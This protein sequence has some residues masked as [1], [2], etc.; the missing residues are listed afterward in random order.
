MITER[1]AIEAQQLLDNETLK[2]ALEV[3]DNDI[4]KEMRNL[5]MDGSPEN[6]SKALELVRQLK[7]SAKFRNVLKQ[8]VSNYKLLNP[9][10]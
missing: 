4:L 10:E 3:I 1:K 7:T 8:R 6:D 5:T 9:E 2:G